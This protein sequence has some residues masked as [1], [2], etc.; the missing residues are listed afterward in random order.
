AL[1]IFMLG[2]FVAVVLVSLTTHD[3]MSLPDDGLTLRWY[4]A[5]ADKPDLAHAAFQSLLLAGA[6]AL[7]ALLLGLPAAWTLA[8]RESRWASSLHMLLM[9]PLDRKSTRLNSSH[10]K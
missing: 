4:A 10:V 5:L 9:T 7:L 3:Y 2:P 8:G 1:P 6:S